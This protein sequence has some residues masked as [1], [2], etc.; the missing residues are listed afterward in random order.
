VG[1]TESQIRDLVAVWWQ[2]GRRDL[3]IGAPSHHESA[4]I[5]GGIL[6]YGY[7]LWWGVAEAARRARCRG[8]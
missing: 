4:V 5:T 3:A 2:G 8:C 1:G 7:G 6:S